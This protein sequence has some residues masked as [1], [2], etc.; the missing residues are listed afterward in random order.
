[1]LWLLK[2]KG[3]PSSCNELCYFTLRCIVRLTVVINVSFRL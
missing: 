3:N 2:Y 1:M